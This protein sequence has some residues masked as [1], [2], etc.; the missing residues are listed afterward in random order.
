MKIIGYVLMY[1]TSYDQTFVKLEFNSKGEYLRWLKFM[2]EFESLDLDDLRDSRLNILIEKWYPEEGEDI[3]YDFGLIDNYGE[4]VNYM[5]SKDF[6]IETHD[7][8]YKKLTT[9]SL[10]QLEY[11]KQDLDI[12]YR[13][14]MPK[15]L[16][17]YTSYVL[18]LNPTLDG[19][20]QFGK[21]S[22]L[23]KFFPSLYSSLDLILKVVDTF[24]EKGYEI[25]K[26][27]EGW[28]VKIF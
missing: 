12:A 26:N 27:S 9:N 15:A 25:I 17:D 3:C 18:G 7:G 24:L 6:F 4:Y 2:E 19:L 28:F 8:L 20:I 13:T 22:D 16:E 5:D 21:P 10:D 23:H 11:S 1:R 14:I